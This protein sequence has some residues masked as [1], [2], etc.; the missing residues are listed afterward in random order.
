MNRRG[1]LAGL[2]A[3][4]A[5]PAIVQAANIMRVAPIVVPR[6]SIFRGEMGEWSGVRFTDSRPLKLADID[7]M[8]AV[9]DRLEFKP[10]PLMVNDEPHYVWYMGPNYAQKISGEIGSVEGFHTFPA[11][12]VERLRITVA[13][14]HDPV[15]SLFDR[16][17]RA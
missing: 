5:A 9:I 14:K 7:R 11:T 12:P 3:A 15:A 6:T 17:L 10:Q 2:L 16:L 8:R 1:F 13:A 4:C